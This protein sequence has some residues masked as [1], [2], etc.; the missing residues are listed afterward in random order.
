MGWNGQYE[1]DFKT[2]GEL[3]IFFTEALSL[4]DKTFVDIKDDSYHRVKCDTVTPIE[5]IDKY[6]SLYTHN[7]V[8]NRYEYNSKRDWAEQEGE[9][10]S[11]TMNLPRDIFLFIYLPLDKFDKLI[12]KYKLKKWN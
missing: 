5:Y 3:R 12:K 8:F 11:C 6:L 10:G 9:I 4:S 7:V 2:D 1:L